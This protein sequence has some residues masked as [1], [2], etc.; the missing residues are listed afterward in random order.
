MIY[1]IP[2]NIFFSLIKQDDF[3]LSAQNDHI[4]ENNSKDFI[5]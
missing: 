3:N 5:I 4:D 1:F 2:F